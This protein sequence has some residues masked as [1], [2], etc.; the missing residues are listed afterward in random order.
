MAPVS[1]AAV[2]NVKGDVAAPKAV[3]NVDIK[4]GKKGSDAAEVEG[5]KLK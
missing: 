2:A 4:K 5:K 1:G 3:F